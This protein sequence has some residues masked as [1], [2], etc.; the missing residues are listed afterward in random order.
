MS[1]EMTP[2]D[3]LRRISGF[4]SFCC[5]E[6]FDKELEKEWKKDI[7]A[8]TQA[9][10]RLEGIDKVWHENEP[11]ESVD[12]NGKHLQEK[13][14]LL[15]DLYNHLDTFILA[16][17]SLWRCCNSKDVLTDLDEENST[18]LEFRCG[19][20]NVCVP[21]TEAEI[22]AIKKACDFLNITVSEVLE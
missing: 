10:D 11:M 15:N 22:S 4:I 16:F 13:Y 8:I 6:Y 21:V 2:K 17:N 7:D 5:Y 12:I 20:E 3:A 19:F 14:D 1:K 18:Y 9:I